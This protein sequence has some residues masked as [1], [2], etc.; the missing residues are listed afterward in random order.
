MQSI[1]TKVISPLLKPDKIPKEIPN[2]L[3]EHQ[4]NAIIRMKEL[5]ETDNRKYMGVYCDQAGVG[6]TLTLLNLISNI[7][8]KLIFLQKNE[9]ISISK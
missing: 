8:K 2:Y 3:F 1:T 9:I 7:L 6:K 4:K 5:E